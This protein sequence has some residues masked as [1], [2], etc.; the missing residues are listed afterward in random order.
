MAGF[1]KAKRADVWIK[2]LEI[3][4]SGSGKSVGALRVGTGLAKKC[5]SGLAYIGTEGSRDLYYAD[6]YDYDLL[7]MNGRRSTT[8]MIRCPEI[9]SRTGES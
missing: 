5:N 2:M 6:K 1:N 7:Q 8:F 3:G 9:L 4:P